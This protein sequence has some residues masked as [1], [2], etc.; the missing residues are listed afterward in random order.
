MR[1][2]A[3]PDA[4]EAFYKDVR[5][6]LLLQTWALTGDLPAAQKAVRD[7]LVIAWHHWRKVTRLDD[8]ESFVRP[9]AWSHALRRHTAR[10]FHRE[11]G[12]DDE[13]RATL[14]ALGKLHLTQRKVLLL[15]YLTTLPL[16]QIARE[17]GLTQPQAE[18][19]LQAATAAFALQRDIPTTSI[20]SVFEPMATLVEE[21]RWPR[22][23]IL[24]RAGA[25]RRRTHTFLG[26]I[27]S[28]AV[29]A[30]SGWLVTDATG[31][32]PALD[33]LS[34]SAPSSAPTDRPQTDG[35]Y[36][37]TAETLLTDAQIA[38]ALPGQWTTD[39]TSD[40]PR[41]AL[42]LPCPQARATDGRGRGTL[43]R[44]FTGARPGMTAGQAT[45]ASAD[46]AGAQQVYATATRWYAAC[47][48]TR[49]QLTSTQT[50]TGIGDEASVVVLR[51]WTAPVRS[52]V[53]GVA[54]TGVLTTT[55][56]TT[57]TP[58]RAQA[59]TASTQLLG[60]AV[61]QVCELPEAG[62]CTTTPAAAEAPPIPIGDHPALLSEIDLPPVNTVD[63]PW[64]GTAPVP[65]DVNVAATRCDNATF[66]GNGIQGD[67][68]RS[69]VIPTA[70][71]LPNEFGLTETVGLLPQQK[72][73]RAFVE[74]IR[75][76]LAECEDSVLG[77]TVTQTETSSSPDRDV[78]IWRVEVE[79]SDERTVVYQMA[80][81][82]N[83]AAVGQLGFVPS[84]EVTMEP[85]AFA[86]LA[87][88]AADRLVN[89]TG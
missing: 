43:L 70:P 75:R 62:A 30:G 41:D 7:A 78:T 17:T 12:V 52:V 35:P 29:L 88:R 74:R 6:R 23:T 64:V 77:S 55:V 83:G 3:D 1:T 36:P 28:V 19:E 11:K 25:A 21:A 32:R 15:A 8:P 45:E 14:A 38:A 82:R 49:L 44:T 4:F 61:Q 72:Q 67:L 42:L 48:G 51:D 9:Q 58:V 59:V 63:Q 84:G 37:L 86:A 65:A 79:I 66:Q 24:T 18:R 13:I 53:V 89:L 57:T 5:G 80:I 2:K 26:A 76:R 31:V 22:T 85:G 27:T 50:V 16:D 34:L 68:T 60:Q 20:R 73:A 87:H 47:T 40:S 33:R 39:L 69:F 71:D 10:P 81:L 46:V 56:I 54:R